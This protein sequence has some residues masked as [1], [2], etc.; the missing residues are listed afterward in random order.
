MYTLLT[1][2]VSV[3]SIT[4]FILSRCYPNTIFVRRVDFLHMSLIHT[5]VCLQLSLI[6]NIHITLCYNLT[7]SHSVWWKL[8][9]AILAFTAKTSKTCKKDFMTALFT[10]NILLFHPTF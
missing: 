7:M 5:L 2:P 10:L 1:L 4:M 3:S 6:V 9:S 8:A